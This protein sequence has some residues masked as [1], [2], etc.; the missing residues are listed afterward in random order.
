MYA[1]ALYVIKGCHQLCD[2]VELGS[3]RLAASQPRI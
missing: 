2:G 3:S 1:G